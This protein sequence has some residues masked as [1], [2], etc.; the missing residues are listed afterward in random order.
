MLGDD[1]PIY[2]DVRLIGLWVLKH[3]DHWISVSQERAA[4]A[5]L[6]EEKRAAL[7]AMTA[8]DDRGDS[9]QR[10]RI[11]ERIHAI[12]VD[13]KH[14]QVML[15]VA[16]EGRQPFPWEEKHVRQGVNP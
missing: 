16:R 5:D 11:K 9:H 7:K 14:H 15:S 10:E 1:N 3:T 6:D 2:D 13:I 8:A 12:H 4:L